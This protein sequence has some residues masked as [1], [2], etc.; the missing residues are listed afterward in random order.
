MG[1]HRRVTT[2]SGAPLGF[3][4]KTQRAKKHF[5]RSAN[6]FLKSG[7]L[8]HGTTLNQRGYLP[9]EQALYSRGDT[10][11]T[12]QLVHSSS[13]EDVTI[14]TEILIDTPKHPNSERKGRKG[15]IRDYKRTKRLEQKIS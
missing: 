4:L 3:F 9:W 2:S 15:R 13:Q 8:E 12:C 11:S 1:D 14:S 10:Q 6:Q 7:D 5:L